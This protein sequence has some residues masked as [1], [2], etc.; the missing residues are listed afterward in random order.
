[1]LIS[2]RTEVEYIVLICKEGGNPNNYN[3]QPTNPKFK[4]VTQ[5]LA[6]EGRNWTALTGLTEYKYV[7]PLWKIV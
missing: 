5:M 6:L 4:N 1:M 7:R 2:R 3:N